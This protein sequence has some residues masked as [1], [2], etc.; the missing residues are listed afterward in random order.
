M[1]FNLS[2]FNNKLDNKPR[3]QIRSWDELCNEFRKPII[4]AEKDGRAFSPATFKGTRAKVNVKHLSMLVL[5]LDHDADLCAIKGQLTSLL[6]Q[7]AIYSTHSHLRKTESNPNGEPRF[8][9]LIPLIEPIPASRFPAL[10]RY[11]KQKAGLPI[12]EAAKDTSRIY[13]VPAIASS[14][15]PFEFYEQVG[16]PLNWKSL[17]LPRRGHKGSS[18][19]IRNGTRNEISDGQRNPTLF[20]TAKKFYEEG[21]SQVAVEAA[22][23]DM[24]L[25]RCKPPLDISEV[26]EIARNAEKYPI[27]PN[28]HEDLDDDEGGQRAAQSEKVV[29]LVEAAGVSLF[30][31]ADRETF[32]T[33]PMG[34]HHENHEIKSKFFRNWIGHRFWE[35]E[36]KVPRSQSLQ[37]ALNTLNG[38]ALFDSPECEVFVRLTESNGNIYL[39]LANEEWQVVEIS[40]VGWRIIE[41]FDSPLKFRRPK[42]LGK[43]PSPIKGGD[44]KAL[45]SHINVVREHYSL[46]LI[47]ILASMRPDKPFPLLILNGEQGSAKSTTSR[48]L[49]RLIDPNKAELRPPPRDER[50]LIIAANNGWLIAL[51]NLAKIPDW[52]SDAFCRLS[53]GGGFGTRTLYE[54]NEETLFSAMRPILLNGITELA[55]RPDL[56]DRALLVN[57]PNISKNQRRDEGTIWRQF[58]EAHAGLLGAFLTALSET[59]QKLPEIRLT[60]LERMADFEKFGVAAETA[61]GIAAGSFQLAYSSN[62]R[63]AV[64]VA[65]DSSPTASIILAFMSEQATWVGTATQLL[66]D[67]K[68]FADNDKKLGIRADDLPKKANL[69]SGE[70]K[71]TAPNLRANGIE[72][73]RKKSGSRTVR[74]E[75]IDKSLSEPSA[76]SNLSTH[77]L[78]ERNLLDAAGDADDAEDEPA[79]QITV[80]KPQQTQGGDDSD[81][82]DDFTREL[83]ERILTCGN[84]AENR[85]VAIVPPPYIAGT[86][87]GKA[88][89]RCSCGRHAFL[90]Q[91]C[92]FCGVADVGSLVQ[93]DVAKKKI[94]PINKSRKRATG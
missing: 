15:A 33:I 43:L 44:P 18:P 78:I 19:P 74:L 53:T 80:R 90:G 21:L 37:D 42:G 59:L 3:D 17:P 31:T 92:P 6:C 25:S 73:K 70:L 67:L 27:N 88:Y 79:S 41:G 47:W 66:A 30:H 28:F 29:R 76:S 85:A 93:D 57:C 75:R 5:D 58:D 50:D 56:L 94:L 7:Y 49:R 87:N 82:A 38:R 61:L 45:L 36:R 16:Q 40:T 62:R 55:N 39:D 48:I 24:N 71:R 60:E 69:L 51:D 86:A 89:V 52:L 64:E 26:S 32:G 20:K 10:W 65:I 13:Y 77:N 81:D 83:Q 46:V 91:A 84:G 23:I 1:R 22:L 4:R 14:E 11:S 68:Q 9:V 54:N 72:F 12:D 63:D 34:L 2:F 8:R 35:S